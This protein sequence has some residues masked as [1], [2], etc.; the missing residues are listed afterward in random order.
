MGLDG[1]DADLSR[2]PHPATREA[3]RRAAQSGPRRII[4][5][6]TPYRV[7]ALDE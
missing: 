6:F 4:I 7:V 2:I 5:A 3:A 1:K